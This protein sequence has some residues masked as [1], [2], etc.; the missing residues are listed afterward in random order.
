MNI[1]EALAQLDSDDDGQWTQD[2]Q[3]TIA[4]VAA[5][6]G[7][8]VKRQEIIEAAPTF[9][10]AA[11]RDAQMADPQPVVQ[12]LHASQAHEEADELAEDED[13]D[14]A[15]GNLDL[16]HD[17]LDLGP[18][19]G[20]PGPDDADAA[21]VAPDGPARGPRAP[22]APLDAD[23]PEGES[24]L[25]LPMAQVLR[26]P[27]LT[28]RAFREIEGKIAAGMAAKRAIEAELTALATQSQFLSMNRDR[29]AK[30]DHGEGTQKD[31]R[32]YLETGQKTRA[33]KADRAK[34]FVAAGTTAK[35]V[36]EQ[37]AVGSKLDRS[38]AR[39]R[40]RGNKRPAPRSLMAG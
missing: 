2:G 30:T 21:D 6:M 36:A 7:R 8:P 10:R 26:S 18:L 29:L 32:A 37:L 19:E 38:M 31:I 24:V 4:A 14:L 39:N 17:E 27:E 22:G 28:E 1:N 20:Q 15:D 25:L 33:E 13:R 3:P 11:A 16:D 12:P 34:R 23:V 40:E 9:N 5:L 35:D